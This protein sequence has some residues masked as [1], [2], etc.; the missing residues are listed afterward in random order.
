MGQSPWSL[1]F[2]A[3]AFA[4]TGRIDNA[5]LLIQKLQEWTHKSYVSPSIFAWV[6]CAAGEI[7]KG[8]DWL[9]KCIDERDA[10]VLVVRDFAIYDPLRSHPRYHALLRKMNLE[11]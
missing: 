5:K 4:K 8:L 10:L 1:A 2:R 6:Y 3:I 9:E 7:D 11:P